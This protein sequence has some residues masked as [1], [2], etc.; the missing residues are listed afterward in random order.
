MNTDTSVTLIDELLEEHKVILKDLEGLSQVCSDANVLKEL[1]TADKD[2]SPGRLNRSESLKRVQES[3]AGCEQ[4]LAVHFEREETALLEIFKRHGDE[5]QMSDFRTM[6]RQHAEITDRMAHSKKQADR[7]I[8]GEISGGHW[9]A[10]ANDML[11]YMNKTRKLIEEHASG[12]R[13]L[14]RT[15]RNAI[16]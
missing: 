3:L 4:G 15:L 9:N 11:T 1:S 10:A 12:E 8:S 2:F 13:Q 14:F 16:A 7:L 6:L 5:K